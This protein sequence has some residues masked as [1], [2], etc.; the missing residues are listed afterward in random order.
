MKILNFLFLVF[1]VGFFFTA[2]N[3]EETKDLTSTN[4][5]E[6]VTVEYSSVETINAIF[7]EYGLPTIQE[8]ADRATERAT[9]EEC[10]RALENLR[11]DINRDSVI[12]GEDVR[13]G[14]ELL[15]RCGGPDFAIQNGSPE[16]NRCVPLRF[17]KSLSRAASIARR[18]NVFDLADLIIISDLVAGNCN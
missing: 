18:I 17:K 8:N 13:L 1:C 2:C 4:A 11:G 16:F 14:A 7:N 12:N 6:E 10:R 3:K 15:T 9:I 5:L